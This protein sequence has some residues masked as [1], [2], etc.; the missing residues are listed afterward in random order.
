MHPKYVKLQVLTF[1]YLQAPLTYEELFTGLIWDLIP[2]DLDDWD[3]QSLGETADV[4]TNVDCIEACKNH[5]DCFQSLFKGDECILG[6]AHIALGVKHMEGDVKWRSYWNKEKIAEWVVERKCKD[7]IEFP[8]VQ[9][10]SWW[11]RDR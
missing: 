7:P 3:N 4:K 1:M 11:S 10:R 8:F 5:Q 6:M 9:E 2:E